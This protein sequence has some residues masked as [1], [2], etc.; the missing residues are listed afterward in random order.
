MTELQDSEDQLG[1][2]AK[3]GEDCA[4]LISWQSENM[5]KLSFHWLVKI[6]GD[7]FM[8]MCLWYEEREKGC[9]VAYV[10]GERKVKLS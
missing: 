3:T 8:S 10:Y 7:N 2:R 1:S 5:C 6:E 4:E 9:Q